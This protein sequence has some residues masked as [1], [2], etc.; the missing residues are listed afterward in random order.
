MSDIVIVSS[1]AVAME[2]K[3]PLSLKSLQT[4]L[5]L[6]HHAY[7]NLLTTDMH[8]LMVQDVVQRLDYKLKD[9]DE[10][11]N[12]MERL[13]T[14]AVRWNILGKIKGIRMTSSLVAEYGFDMDN[15]QLLWS[16]PVGL[17]ELLYKPKIYT[18]FSLNEIAS[19]EN[20]PQLRLHQLLKDYQ[21]SAGGTGWMTL[22]QFQ[23][24][25]GTSYDRWD[26]IKRYLIDAPLKVIN[27][28]ESY[29]YTATYATR[30][31]GRKT[32][33]LRFDMTPK[34]CLSTLKTSSVDPFAL[35]IEGAAQQQGLSAQT[36]ASK[37][38]KRRTGNSPAPTTMSAATASAH[39]AH[40]AQIQQTPLYAKPLIVIPSMHE[41][42]SDEKAS[43]DALFRGLSTQE[44]ARIL[45]EAEHRIPPFV[46]ELV[47]AGDKNVTQLMPMMLT[48]ARNELLRSLYH[49]ALVSEQHTK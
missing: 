16:Y 6:L 5:V 47:E 20:K 10:L 35:G 27:T 43:Y 14:T 42:M 33:H 29:T 37:K 45:R 4:F 41:E 3:H 18:K 32:A 21:G 31:E 25:M 19:I 24:I 8:R 28:T 7:D 36:T 39:A 9:Y 15:R 48:E 26:N 1:A 17:R 44:Q 23:D 46:T 11:E 22:R 13:R 34:L 30:K 49:E 12:A 40:N 38:G 2:A